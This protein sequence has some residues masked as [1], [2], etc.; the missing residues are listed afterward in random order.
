MASS[1]LD[2][3][4]RIEVLRDID[5]PAKAASPSPSIDEKESCGGE[6]GGVIGPD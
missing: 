3:F 2:G 4:F 1:V 6:P 5:F